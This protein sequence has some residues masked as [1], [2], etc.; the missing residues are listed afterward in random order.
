MTATVNYTQATF[1]RQ[2]VYLVLVKSQ[3]GCNVILSFNRDSIDRPVKAAS[4]VSFWYD[5]VSHPTAYE[6]TIEKGKDRWENS[7]TDYI[8]QGTP[9]PENASIWFESENPQDELYTYEIGDILT[10]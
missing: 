10:Q 9:Y 4:N 5:S 8:E 2:T 3:N 7:S 1:Q 6:Y